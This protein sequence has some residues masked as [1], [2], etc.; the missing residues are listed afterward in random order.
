MKEFAKGFMI[1]I[2]TI[3]PEAA[4]SVAAVCCIACVMFFAIMVVAY[5]VIH[6]AR[7]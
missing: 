5:V 2:N 4:G 6:V 1:V 3:T 7:A